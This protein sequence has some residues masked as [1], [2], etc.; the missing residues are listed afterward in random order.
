MKLLVISDSHSINVENI[1]R[2]QSLSSDICEMVLFLGDLQPEIVSLLAKQFP[3]QRKIGVL[4][5]HDVY[6]SYEGT[7]VEDVHLQMVTEKDI[8]FA[9]LEGS[10]RY[11]NSRYPAY[12]QGESVVLASTL[13]PADI[14]ISHTSPYGINERD[15]REE[16]GFLGLKNYV[17]SNNPVYHFHGHQ[18]VNKVT[19]LE[20]RTSVICVYGLLLFDVISGESTLLIEWE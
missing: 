14:L 12:T 11:K 3:T 1:R 18:H 4:G 15:G 10:L 6:G 19:I 9:G 7:G 17:D 8:T 2:L 16:E 20:N 13:P 5:N